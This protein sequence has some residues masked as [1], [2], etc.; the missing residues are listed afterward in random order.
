MNLLEIIKDYFKL[1]G[2]GVS[3]KDK[4][5]IFL[6]FLN[7][8]IHFLLN[9]L[10]IKFKHKLLGNVTVK[11]EDGI[12]FCGNRIG[13]VW[14]GSNFHER[15]IRSYFDI[16]K[17]NF[18]DAGAN[19][20]KFSVIVAK[21]LGKKGKVFSIEPHPENFKMLK[22]NIELNGLKNVVPIN[23]A[24]SY[25]EGEI[26]LHLDEEGTGGHSIKKYSKSAGKKTMK[27]K[28]ILL[29]NLQIKNIKLIKI[30]VEGA[31]ADVLRGAKK[32]LKRDHPKIIFEA[33][34]EECLDEIKII[35]N[36]FKYQIKK[37]GE[38]NYFAY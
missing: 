25:S 12:F 13:S 10:K 30:D 31:E 28:S 37:I 4:S 1:I 22:K 18:I 21:R 32:I 16:A 14:A 38:E 7:S 36:P 27:V 26:E 29:D 19:I 11:S 6:Y 23:A 33:W 34:D 24:C 3:L 35:L 15:E 8:P 17:G 20:G 9:K 2:Q 5:I